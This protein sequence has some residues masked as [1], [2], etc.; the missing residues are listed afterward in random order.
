MRLLLLLIAGVTLLWGSNPARAAVSCGS[1]GSLWTMGAC[2]TEGMKEYDT[3]YG[4]Y[5]FCNGTNYV[6]MRGDTLLGSCTYMQRAVLEYDSSLANYKFCDGSSWVSMANNGTQGTCGGTATGTTEYDTTNH[7]LKWCNGTNWIRMEGTTGGSRCIFAT[8][9]TYNGSLGGA[10]YGLAK[11][12]SNC[13]AR[14]AAG[15]GGA[16]LPGTYKAWMSDSATSASSRLS[17]SARAYKMVDGSQIASDW[18]DLTDGTMKMRLRGSITPWATMM[19][20]NYVA[21]SGNYAYVTAF[22]ANRLNVVD[23]SNPETPTIVGS[24][25]DDS[26]M[27]SP[28]G[29][30]VSGNY[31]FVVSETANPGKIAV[32]DVSAPS[33]PRLVA[34]YSHADLY[35]AE[36][37]FVSGNYLYVAARSISKLAVVD[38]SNPTSPVLSGSVA[39]SGAAQ[40]TVSGNYAYV[41]NTGNNQLVIVDVSTPASPTI[42]GTLTDA[43][44]L[45]DP[46]GMVVSG[47]YAYVAASTGDRLTV[48]DVTNKALSLI[49]I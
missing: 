21:V 41:T 9:T 19:W 27:A 26:N 3:T 49:H 31:V 28:N 34:T 29:V 42:S 23:I 13:V 32:I 47:N 48:V 39:I 20:A 1:N 5:K 38:I 37:V 6:G 24:V 14:A 44:N 46:W 33:A 40:V 22:N 17:H 2:A 16:G 30:A 4:T 43:T 8:S 15:D 36:G 35:G 7:V 18:N 45:D 11:A 25:K 10:P 12:D